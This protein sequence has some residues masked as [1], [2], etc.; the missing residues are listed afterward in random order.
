MTMMRYITPTLDRMFMDSLEW[1]DRTYAEKHKTEDPHNLRAM[2]AQNLEK[3]PTHAPKDPNE[4]K[5]SI[6]DT[7]VLMA[8]K[9]GRKAGISLAVLALSY[10]PYVGKFVLPAASFY[11]F[12]KAVGPQPAVAIFAGSLLLPRRYLVSF[13]QAYFSSRTLMRELLEPYFTRVRYNKEQKK[14][15]FKDRA[16]VLFGFGLGFYIFVKIPLVGVLIYGLAEASTAY[17]ITKITEPPLP[18]N[19]AEKFK[20]ESLRWKNKHE[21]LELPWQHM[22][23]YNIS[24][25]KP[26]FKSDV[27]QTP[28]KAFS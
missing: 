21:F 24:M 11:T 12:N 22:D 28:R 23:S 10:L 9:Q 26:G 13:L 2:Y 15:W 8:L 18:P 14:L 1:V 16:G 4:K 27:R 3:Y 7:V 6:K 25:H 17:L 5:K 19:E 20:E